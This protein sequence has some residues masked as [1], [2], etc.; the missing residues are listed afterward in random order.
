MTVD[1]QTLLGIGTNRPHRSLAGHILTVGIYVFIFGALA[2]L[3]FLAQ[4]GIP[5]QLLLIYVGSVPVAIAIGTVREIAR[6][7]QR[8]AAHHV[9]AGCLNLMLLCGVGGIW[10]AFGR[11]LILTILGS[12]VVVWL[13]RYSP[14]SQFVSPPN[15]ADVAGSPPLLENRSV[16]TLATL[17]LAMALL[18]GGV[19]LT[20]LAVFSQIV[21]PGGLNITIGA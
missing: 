2:Y 6:A 15:L 13:T 10:L 20:V 7:K 16:Q 14:V 18:V 3:T 12:L 8:L 11:Q 17:A 5:G 9:V 1:P 21:R 19:G 4:G